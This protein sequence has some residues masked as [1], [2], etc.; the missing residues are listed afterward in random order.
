MAA[1]GL[2]LF[3]LQER[4]MTAKDILR[5]LYAS[6][7]TWYVLRQIFYKFT[8]KAYKEVLEPA[9]EIFGVQIPFY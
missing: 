3:V 6:L 5:K 1:I 9:P 8:K 2:S 7:E 4:S